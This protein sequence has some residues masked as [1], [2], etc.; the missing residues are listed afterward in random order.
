MHCYRDVGLSSPRRPGRSTVCKREAQTLRCSATYALAGGP[1]LPTPPPVRDPIIPDCFTIPT[2]ERGVDTEGGLTFCG[3]S[4][5]HCLAAR[6]NLDSGEAVRH[7]TNNGPNE[8]RSCFARDP[9][10]P[11]TWI[12]GIEVPSQ[13]TRGLPKL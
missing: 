7:T 13:H 8:V 6:A 3:G 12:T 5:A 10:L 4:T 2:R 1:Q 9:F 11:N